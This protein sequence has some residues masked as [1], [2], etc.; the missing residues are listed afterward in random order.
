MA[1]ITYGKVRGDTRDTLGQLLAAH[2]AAASDLR[3]LMNGC[4][5]SGQVTAAALLDWTGRAID[6]L[7]DTLSDSGGQ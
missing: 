7:E 4:G 1:A 5:T 6:D 3:R 2:R